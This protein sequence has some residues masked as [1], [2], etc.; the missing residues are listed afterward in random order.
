MSPTGS[1][2]CQF[3]WT[4]RAPTNLSSCSISADYHT[5]TEECILVCALLWPLLDRFVSVSRVTF[6]LC[7]TERPRLDMSGSCAHCYAPI[8]G[9]P[10]IM[11][12]SWRVL[13]C[14]C[15]GLGNLGKGGR[16][17]NLIYVQPAAAGQGQIIEVHLAIVGHS[18]WRLLSLTGSTSLK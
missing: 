16:E 13:L 7:L 11:S 3:G 17:G 4:A 15:Q 9:R 12:N 14:A 8:T 2:L 1:C 18:V 10:V 5:A 6:D